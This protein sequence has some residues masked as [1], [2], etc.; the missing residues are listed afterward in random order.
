MTPS[1]SEPRTILIVD[2][3]PDLVS[4]IRRSLRNERY[5]L[6]CTTDPR[7]AAGWLSR[8]TI[9]VIL[10]DI[11]MPGMSGHDL[12]RLA[13]QTCPETI[14]VL[15]TGAGTM[16]SAV[17]AINEG[18]VHRYVCKPFEP[19]L[20]RQLV[21]EALARYEELRTVSE[22]GR[23]AERRKLL[24]AHLEAEHPGITSIAR[25][26]EG[27]YTIDADQVKAAATRLG[28]TPFLP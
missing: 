14:R 24:Y 18:E 23:R 3:E 8:E 21:A 11:D 28:L 9:H 26:G 5:Q 22:A 6:R 16:E 19:Q 27:I 2:D 10:S 7:E 15:I 1:G 13:R 20:L 25:D 4:A 12:M 17:R